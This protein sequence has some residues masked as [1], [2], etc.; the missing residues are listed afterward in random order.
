MYFPIWR[1]YSIINLCLTVSLPQISHTT[2]KTLHLKNM[3]PRPS[4]NRRNGNAFYTTAPQ[5]PCSS[6]HIIPSRSPDGT[7]IITNNADNTLRTYLMYD[8]NSP[9]LKDSKPAGL[10]AKARSR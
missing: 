7:S 10:P 6:S 5:F 2:L 1:K 9:S 4:S 3:A 8:D